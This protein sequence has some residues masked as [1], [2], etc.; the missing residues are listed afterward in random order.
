[1]QCSAVRGLMHAVTKEGISSSA[2]IGMAGEAFNIQAS[3]AAA[4]NYKSLLGTK[5]LVKMR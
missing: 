2:S 4:Q 3:D 1:M 5:S